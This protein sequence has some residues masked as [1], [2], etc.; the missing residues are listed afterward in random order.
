MLGVYRFLREA[1]AADRLSV[2]QFTHM[3]CRTLEDTPVFLLKPCD[4]CVKHRQI[5]RVE[6]KDLIC[7]DEIH[8]AEFQLDPQSIAVRTEYKPCTQTEQYSLYC[9]RLCI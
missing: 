2:L 3:A 1:S 5:E 9:G 4:L 7:L 8:S 6:E